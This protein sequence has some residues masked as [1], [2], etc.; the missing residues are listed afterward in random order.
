MQHFSIDVKGGGIPG[1]S[2]GLLVDV[3][4]SMQKGETIGNVVIDG[5]EDGKGLPPEPAIRQSRRQE[6]EAVVR[7][8]K[9]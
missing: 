5:K 4:P 7:K 8:N 3:L 1:G 6:V 2:I 9:R